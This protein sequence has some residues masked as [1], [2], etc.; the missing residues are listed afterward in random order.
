MP[1]PAVLP[2]L[3]TI[4]GIAAGVLLP[5]LRLPALIAS[6]VAVLMAVMAW[7]AGWVGTCTALA[8]TGF[9]AAGVLLGAAQM[10]AATRSPLREFFDEARA[11][12]PDALPPIVVEGTLR[13]D[14]APAEYG[15]S[16][17]LD[18]RRVRTPCGWLPARGGL[19]V[20]VNGS[21]VGGLIDLWRAGRR[22]RLPVLLRLPATFR[23]PGVPDDAFAMARRGIALVGSAKSGALVEVVGTG[24]PFAEAAGAVRAYARR[25]VA[26]ALPG[27]P[28]AA[29]IVTAILV[30]DRGGLDP[31]L[32][33]RLQEAGTY[34][35]IAISGGNVAILA[36]L[37]FVLLRMLR[38][39]PRA[40]SLALAGSLCAYGY[41]AGGGPSVAR[42]T[43]A[44]AVYLVA[45]AADHRSPA[46]NVLASVALAAVIYEP[47]GVFDPGLLLSYGATLA[48][49]IGVDRVLRRGA[50]T[51]VEERRDGYRW[52]SLR[53]LRVS[54][55]S[56]SL[57]VFAGTV[58]AELALFPIG[59]S[60][61]HRVTLAGLALNFAAIPL[62]TV[63]QVGGLAVLALSP[64]SL[65]L[66]RSAGWVAALAADGLTHSTMLLDVAPW[67]T[68][69]VPAPPPAIVMLYYAG[70]TLGLLIRRP[71]ALRAAAFAASALSSLLIVCPA[72]T[73]PLIVRRL[74][75]PDQLRVTFLDVGQGDSI[76]VQFPG[77][78]AMLVD[79]A[80]LPGSSFDVGE[81]VITPA[82]LAL[83]V[84][85]LQYLAITHGDADHVV[86][87][88]SVAHDFDPR[89]V[90]EGVPVPPHEVLRGLREMVIARGGAARLVRPDDRVQVGRVEVR[91]LHPPEP[92]WERQRVRN[93]DSIVSELRYGD[94]SIVLTGDIGAAIEE[95]LA[96]KLSDAPIR[97]LKAAHHGSATSSAAAWLTAARPAAVVVSCGRD[98][99]YGHPAPVVLQRL[100]GHGAQIFRTDRDGAVTVTT[101]G[102][103]AT[104]TTFSGR[105]SRLTTKFTKITKVT[106][107]IQQ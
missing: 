9:C 106:K 62:M 67:L 102:T 101:D 32:E 2:A 15:A 100:A 64:I 4:A 47:L 69:R 98:N 53:T 38:V 44:A 20:A 99:R 50:S 78:A 52:Q 65:A 25:A 104:V 68:W 75:A 22:V 24:H 61:F 63:A 85:R 31:A 70:W 58:C 89:E 56:A 49:L 60:I 59:A 43:L 19:R 41:I 81:R 51:D 107:E 48:L 39:P 26:A 103:S 3:T 91:V 74:P 18:V 76:L 90:W 27:R 88:P 1:A 23:D 7:R 55:T 95:S 29:A 96:A 45:T 93:D 83:G 73:E 34:H 84:R 35:V 5:Q 6:I 105:K 77:S 30:G 13:A 71:R 17:V 46:L 21:L 11:A 28:V 54:A 72:L 8:A 37:A 97:I 92:D 16:M 40:G 14:A 79:A 12:A 10:A 42:A 57:A 82:L 87:A 94:V 66:G 80:G 33:R 86:G 36:G